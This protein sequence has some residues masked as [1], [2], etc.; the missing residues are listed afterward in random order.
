MLDRSSAIGASRKGGAEGGGEG[1]GGKRGEAKEEEAEEVFFLVRGMEQEG[2]DEGVE[3]IGLEAE[4][5]RGRKG[6]ERR[7]ATVTGNGP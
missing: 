2:R 5:E 7:H 6:E 3:G 1:G 4:R